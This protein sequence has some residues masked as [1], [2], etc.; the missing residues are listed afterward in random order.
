LKKANP[1]VLKQLAPFMTMN[2]KAFRVPVVIRTRIKGKLVNVTLPV[3]AGQADQGSDMI[4][5]SVGLLR[6]LHLKSRALCDRGF[7]GLTMNVADGNIAELTHYATFKIGVYGIWRRVEA[8][9][10]PC[11]ERNV[12]DIHLLL[13]MPWLHSVNA[14][15]LIRE[16]VIEIGD[17][18]VGERTVR[19]QGPQFVEC[20]NHKLVLHPA[21]PTSRKEHLAESSDEDDESSDDSDYDTSDSNSEN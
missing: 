19:I 16:S 11:N 5:A 9:V 18:S 1:S 2:Q 15:I 10:R 13:G 21:V 3:Y 12:D 7:S 8:F 17:P 14:K 20:K 4:V 6:T